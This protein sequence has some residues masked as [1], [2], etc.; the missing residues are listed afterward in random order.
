MVEGGTA[1]G[2]VVSAPPP[3]PNG[4]FAP[5]VFDADRIEQK[6]KASLVRKVRKLVEDYPE[7]TLE[8]IRGW[9]AEGRVH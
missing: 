5:S 8:I 6:V 9:M 2:P 4:Q 1:A 3:E 7:R